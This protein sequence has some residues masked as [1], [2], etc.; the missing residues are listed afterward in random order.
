MYH[1]DGRWNAFTQDNFT[2]NPALAGQQYAGEYGAGY[3]GVEQGDQSAQGADAAPM[4]QAQGR[5]Y[6]LQH[7][8]N[9]REFICDNGQ[10]VYFDQGQA[11]ASGQQ[12]WQA[13][14]QPTPTPAM[15]QD[16][17][18]PMAAGNANGVSGQPGIQ[19]GGQVGAS[20]QQSGSVQTGA[21]MHAGASTQGAGVHAG[22]STPTQPGASVQGG[23]SATVPAQPLQGSATGAASG[24]IQGSPSR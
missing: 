16:P 22:A 12:Q 18:A 11:S 24:A 23:A 17:N 10:R 7:D 8:P 21:G 13:G 3:R 1:R 15:P 20:T 9:G 14:Y 6:R 2:P 5:V 4:A 19:A